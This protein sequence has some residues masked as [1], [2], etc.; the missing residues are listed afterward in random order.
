[1]I[2]FDK[3]PQFKTRLK[4]KEPQI[5]ARTHDGIQNHENF[6]KL[7][8]LFVTYIEETP[9]VRVTAVVF[10]NS[11]VENLINDVKEKLFESLDS[12]EV[13]INDY[14][15]LNRDLK[16]LNIDTKGF[17]DNHTADDFYKKKSAD[18]CIFLVTPL[19]VNPYVDGENIGSLVFLNSK[20]LRKYKQ[21]KDMN[22][23]GDVFAAYR[24]HITHRFNYAPFF[25]KNS[26]KK[27]LHKHLINKGD[28]VG[29]EE[30]F[31]T[32]HTQLLNNKPEDS[33]RESLRFYLKE[34][35]GNY[36]NFAKEYLLESFKRL[37]INIIDNYGDLY[38]IE[39]K[40][41]G[42]SIGAHGDDFG[43]TYSDAD[44]NPGAIRQTVRYIH[45]L[46]KNQQN[47]IIG[48]LVVFD[49]RDEDLPDS[50]A[51]FDQSDLEVGTEKSYKIL[52]KIDD[53]RVKNNHPS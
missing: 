26:A 37:D 44:I 43:I 52:H 22:Q 45:E 1:M 8:N 38:F 41:I 3:D 50:G 32:E 11:E 49:A 51:G 28:D 27:G 4:E 25:A 18:T 34:N 7:H 9:V 20:D 42:A 10:A 31:L 5:R 47:V 30:D 36:I 53:F 40:W 39:V 15:E 46:H 33:F 24:T 29:S 12:H 35:M 6:R 16:I 48:Y 23:I 21:L 2:D 19:G 13:R 17:D 14:V